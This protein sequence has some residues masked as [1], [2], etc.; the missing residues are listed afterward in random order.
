MENLPAWARQDRGVWLLDIH[1]Q[2]G[3]RISAVVGEHGGRLKIK[4]SAQPADNAANEALMEFI[5]KA[6]AVPRSRV[7]LIRGQSS[8]LKTLAVECPDPGLPQQFLK[9]NPTGP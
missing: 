2:P 8:R 1:V 4:I 9:R 5:A 6:A 3:A 7:K